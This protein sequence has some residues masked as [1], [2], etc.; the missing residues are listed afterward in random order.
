MTPRN[1]RSVRT[2]P[3][4]TP[5]LQTNHS[6]ADE[7]EERGAERASRSRTGEKPLDNCMAKTAPTEEG[8]QYELFQGSLARANNRAQDRYPLIAHSTRAS[9][10][11]VSKWCVCGNISK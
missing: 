1:S 5:P 2:G 9:Q 3:T 4:V 10:A 11:K 7:G 8:R 6:G